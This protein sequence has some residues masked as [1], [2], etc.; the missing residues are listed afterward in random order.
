MKLTPIREIDVLA[1]SREFREIF[2][3]D[4]GWALAAAMSKVQCDPMSAPR[5]IA[6]LQL[7][8]FTRPQAEEV[9]RQTI[10]GVTGKK[11]PPELFTG[12][13]IVPQPAAQV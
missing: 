12:C 1:A 7:A 2:G 4:K 11:P 13:G 8:G 5:A 10:I 6:D 9:V 3:E